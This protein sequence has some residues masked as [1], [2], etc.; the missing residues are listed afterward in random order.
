MLILYLHYNT[1]RSGYVVSLATPTK[2]EPLYK[3]HT[4]AGSA[5]YYFMIEVVRSFSSIYKSTLG[6][7]PHF[8]QSVLYQRFTI[9]ENN[10]NNNNIDINS[11]SSSSD[12]EVHCKQEQDQ[13]QQHQFQFFVFFIRG[14][15]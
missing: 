4:H 10:N 8:F 11:L 1:N 2:A 14:S 9:N 7:F 5:S 13:Q 12:L 6:F 15:L 3:V